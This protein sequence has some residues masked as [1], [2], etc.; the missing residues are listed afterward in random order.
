L[1]RVERGEE[2]VATSTMVV[3]ETVFTLQ[4]SYKLPRRR[5][6]ELVRPLLSLR[7]LAIP[8]R[9]LLERALDLFVETNVP[10]DDAYNVAFMEASGLTEIYSWDDDFD[11]F[12]GLGRI[13]P[14]GT[15]AG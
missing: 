10:F 7:G 9:S 14:T 15:A 12:S 8:E 4:R 13:E 6:H 1:L 5:I 3:F 2:R 11:R